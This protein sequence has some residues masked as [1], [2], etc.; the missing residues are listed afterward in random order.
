[1]K[2][3][4]SAFR[5]CYFEGN[6]N[7]LTAQILKYFNYKQNKIMKKSNNQLVLSF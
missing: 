1:M 6:S 2:R 5:D 3:L 4:K 7:Q